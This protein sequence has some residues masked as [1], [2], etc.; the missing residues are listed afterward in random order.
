MLERWTTERAWIA[1]FA[2]LALSA[3]GAEPFTTLPLRPQ[4]T[5]VMMGLTLLSVG[6]ASC[7]V[8]VVDADLLSLADNHRIAFDNGYS[9]IIVAAGGPVRVEHFAMVNQ[10]QKVTSRGTEA[11]G[12]GDWR[13]NDCACQQLRLVAAA[14]DTVLIRIAVA[15]DNLGARITEF[16][17][18]NPTK[19]KVGIADPSVSRQ[20]ALLDIAVR[21]D[22]DQIIPVLVDL[23]RHPEPMLRWQALR[24]LTSHKPCAATAILEDFALHDKDIG[25]RAVAAHTLA[26]LAQ[27]APKTHVEQRA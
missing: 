20:L 11:L 17:L 2:S 10:G 26:I 5:S 23:C 8:S 14:Q 3:I 24:F 27:S 21:A 4:V 7:T 19:A 9:M 13:A 18:Q 16:D 25:V 22:D 15:A 6:R 1:D 12:V